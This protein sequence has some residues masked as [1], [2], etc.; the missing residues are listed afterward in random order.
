MS[1]RKRPTPIREDMTAC[2]TKF[3]GGYQLNPDGT[4]SNRPRRR[5]TCPDMALYGKARVTGKMQRWL[6][7]MDRGHDTPMRDF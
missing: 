4:R 6:R 7:E 1:K 5:D 2:E 3:W